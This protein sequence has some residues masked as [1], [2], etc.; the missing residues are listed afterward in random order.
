MNTTL[1]ELLN[2]RDEVNRRLA[3]FEVA[4]GL[5]STLAG[6]VGMNA[7]HP[8]LMAHDIYAAVM[9]ERSRAQRAYA[10]LIAE[11]RCPDCDGFLASEEFYYYR[12]CDCNAQWEPTGIRRAD[13][14]EEV[15]EG[16]E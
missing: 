15:S 12:C 5:L 2:N 16:A 9:S 14:E 13:F 8:E 7:E 3:R 1:T 4:M 6:D 11:E 10:R